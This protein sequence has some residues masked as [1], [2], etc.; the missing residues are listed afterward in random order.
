M[1]HRVF[2]TPLHSPQSWVGETS[3]GG[4]GGPGTF[5]CPFP[6]R[7]SE[8]QVGAAP[9]WLREPRSSEGT[10][11]LLQCRAECR[12]Q[13]TKDTQTLQNQG[14]RLEGRIRA[15][16]RAVLPSPSVRLGL[17]P[18]QANSIHSQAASKGHL[19]HWQ[20]WEVKGHKCNQ[21]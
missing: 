3:A 20:V 15:Q 16:P 18:F 17:H 5:P 19:G 13:K 7:Q 6:P 8:L 2:S 9:A 1:L 10:P 11:V 14:R 21:E 12:L 4:S